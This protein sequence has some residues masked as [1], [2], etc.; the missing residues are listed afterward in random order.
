MSINISTHKHIFLCNLAKEYEMDF[1]ELPNGINARNKEVSLTLY[2]GSKGTF[3]ID[4]FNGS[5]EIGTGFDKFKLKV[6]EIFGS[7]YFS[8][9][10]KNALDHLY[11]GKQVFKKSAKG[12]EE[13]DCELSPIAELF[14][15]NLYGKKFSIDVNG[16]KFLKKEDAINFINRMGE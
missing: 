16:Q 5:V 9:A 6:A 10:M 14:G 11:E 4:R 12:Y 2:T 7:E 1:K 8:I 13:I 15:Q 3:C